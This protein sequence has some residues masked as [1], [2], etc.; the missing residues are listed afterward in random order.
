ME[1]DDFHMANLAFFLN[2]TDGYKKEEIEA[3]LYRIIF[4][5]K[6]MTHYDRGNG[7]SFEDIE[8]EK[9]NG[10]IVFLFIRNIVSSVYRLNESRNFDPYIIVDFSDINTEI[11]NGEFLIRIEYRLLQDLQV[12]GTVE[13]VL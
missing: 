10:A 12:E 11:K 4:Q 6:E 13:A 9:E 2:Y 8:Q 1:A 3:E 7:G 5:T